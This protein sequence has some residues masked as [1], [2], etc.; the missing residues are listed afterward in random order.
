[1]DT[2]TIAAAPEVSTWLMMFMGFAGL[3][4]VGYGANRKRA[5]IA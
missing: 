3:G 1:V 5:V 4:S 2:L